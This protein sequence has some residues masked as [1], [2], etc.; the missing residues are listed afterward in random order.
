MKPKTKQTLLWIFTVFM[1]VSGIAFFPSVFS[2]LAIV[3]AA[4]CAPVKGLQDFWKHKKLYGITKTVLLVVLFIGCIG[5]VPPSEKSKAGGEPTE[6]VEQTD[7]EGNKEAEHS[8]QPEG[9]PQPPVGKSEGPHPSAPEDEPDPVAELEPQP[10]PQSEPDQTTQTGHRSDTAQGPGLDHDTVPQPEPEKVD[11]EQAFRESL[12]QYNYVGSSESDKYHRPTCRWT[13]DINDS[14]L[15]HFDT[16]E[17]AQAANY[18]PCKTCN[19]G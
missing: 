18:I 9:E 2:V 12:A 15:V 1:A 4:V 19:P 13:S 14:N 16:I 3:F 11:P 7:N 8:T 6:V 5:T 17:E 10:E